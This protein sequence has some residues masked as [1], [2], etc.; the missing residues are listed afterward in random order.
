MNIQLLRHG[1]AF[2]LALVGLGT[3]VLADVA[4]FKCVRVTPNFD[5]VKVSDTCRMDGATCLGQCVW[6]K[7]NTGHQC[8]R[9]DEQKACDVVPSPGA[10]SYLQTVTCSE[11]NCTCNTWVDGNPWQSIVEYPPFCR[12]RDPIIWPG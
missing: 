1:L 4:W 9:T 7:Q 6:K 2:A 10:L 11:I 3:V 5:Y 12:T 8:A